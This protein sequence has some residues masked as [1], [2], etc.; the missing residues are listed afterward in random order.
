MKIWKFFERACLVG[1]EFHFGMTN[2]D[3]NVLDLEESLNLGQALGI[4]KQDMTKVFK[5][6]DTT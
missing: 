6:I 3:D 2:N 1:K 4:M 5:S